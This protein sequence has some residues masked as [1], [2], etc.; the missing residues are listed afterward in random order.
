LLPSAPDVMRANGKYLAAKALV[1][2]GLLLYVYMLGSAW[3]II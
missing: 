3:N 1:H 2:V